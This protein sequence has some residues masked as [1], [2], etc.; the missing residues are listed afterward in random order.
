MKIDY[1]QKLL[2]SLWISNNVS[3]STLNKK[4]DT[5]QL[6]KN[7]ILANLKLLYYWFH[8][9]IH[10]VMVYIDDIHQVA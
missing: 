9:K 1:H 2:H 4:K 10:L 3:I 5:K 6:H 8:N 7:K